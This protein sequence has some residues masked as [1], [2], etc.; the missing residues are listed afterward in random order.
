[1]LR[2]WLVAPSL[3]PFACRSRYTQGDSDVILFHIYARRFRRHFVGKT[4]INFCHCNLAYTLCWSVSDHEGI[5]S[6]QTDSVYIRIT[7]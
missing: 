6:D 4:S 3:F 5:F 2:E 7:R 1:M